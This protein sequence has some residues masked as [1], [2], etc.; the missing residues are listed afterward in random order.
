MDG[1]TL[2][3]IDIN[4]KEKLLNKVALPNSLCKGLDLR[5]NESINE[6][7]SK[8]KDLLRTMGTQICKEASKIGEIPDLLANK[9]LSK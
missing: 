4:T 5:D 7:K 8:V 9:N 1:V 6:I 3:V 2:T